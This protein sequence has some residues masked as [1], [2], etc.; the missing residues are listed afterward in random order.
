M[1]LRQQRRKARPKKLED[2]VDLGRAA[3]VNSMPELSFGSL[4]HLSD[5]VPNDTFANQQEQHIVPVQEYERRALYEYDHPAQ[6]QV[7]VCPQAVVSFRKLVERW[8][9]ERYYE[10]EGERVTR[11]LSREEL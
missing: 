1:R 7:Y 11:E 10:T 4:E 9:S 5:T 6:G 8:E 2:E 3:G